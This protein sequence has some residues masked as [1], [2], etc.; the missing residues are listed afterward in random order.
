MTSVQS[1]LFQTLTNKNPNTVI[2]DIQV[3]GFLVNMKEHTSVTIP[4]SVSVSSSIS[5]KIQLI[6]ISYQCG[7]QSDLLCT[8]SDLG[9]LKCF[10]F[11]FFEF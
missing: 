4:M 5:G 1:I 10:A 8:H 2:W 7:S 9:T 6:D 11:S 3:T